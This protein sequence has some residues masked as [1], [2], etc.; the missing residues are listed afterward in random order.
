MSTTEEKKRHESFLATI[1]KVTS[2]KEEAIKYLKE[3]G[4]L[5]S[6]GNLAEI[7]R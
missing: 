1:K 3:A 5:D 2:S 4:F 6:E 7:Y